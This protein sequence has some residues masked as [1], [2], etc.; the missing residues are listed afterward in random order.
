MNSGFGMLKYSD[1]SFH[2][3]GLML[4][5]VGDGTALIWNSGTWRLEQKLQH[6]S[7][8]YTAQFHPNSSQLIATA[9]FDRVIRMWRK[10]REQY[11]VTQVGYMI[12]C[13]PVIGHR[14]LNTIYYFVHHL[15]FLGT[16]R[17]QLP[18]QLRNF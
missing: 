18:H 15:L 14:A 8:V 9:G 11:I 13:L 16:Y 2:E 10:E 12:T 17:S 4:A 7:Y 3:D 6:P 1:F 5:A